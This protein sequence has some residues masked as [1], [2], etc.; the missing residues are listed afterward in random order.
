M[1]SV[2]IVCLAAALLTVQTA[3]AQSAV[4]FSKPAAKEPHES[5]F[6]GKGMD[7]KIIT[8]SGYIADVPRFYS[9]NDGKYQ[10]WGFRLNAG[11]DQAHGSEFISVTVHTVKWSKT[12]G[13]FSGKKGE[14][15]TLSGK[16]SEFKGTRDGTG[17]LGSLSVNDLSLDEVQNLK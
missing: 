16:F 5:Q 10:S 2:L 12:V 1:E 3:K 11:K 9:G 4:E 8:L 14:E 7:G 13:A 15:V 6:Y 17:I